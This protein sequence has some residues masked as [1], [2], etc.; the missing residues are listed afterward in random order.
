[1]RIEFGWSLDGASWADAASGGMTGQVR[2]GPRGL[3]GLL[4]TRLGLTRPAIDQAVRIAQYLRLIEQCIESPTDKA[5]FWPARSF[6]LDPWSTARQLLRWRD[7]AVEAGWSPDPKGTILP[8]R[9]AALATIERRAVVGMVGT[10]DAAGNPATLAP[11]AADDLAEMVAELELGAIGWPLGIQQLVAQKDP[12]ALPGLWPRLLELLGRAG[13]EVTRAEARAGGRP[14]VV[15]VQCRD[16]WTAAD[17][18]ARYLSAGPR[19]GLH[20]LATTDTAVLD[21]ALH[22]RDLPA[23]GAVE[24]STDRA[25]HQVLGLYLDVA[26]A[27]VDV[28]QLA[29]LLDLRVLPALEPEGDPIGLVPAPVRRALLRALASE[30]GVGGP[31]WRAALARLEEREDA[32]KV[33]VSAREID[34]LVSDPLPAQAL[35]PEALSTR[36]GWLADRLRA[37]GHRDSDLRASLTQ[38]QTLRQVLG[39]LDPSTTLS[40]RTLQQ[41]ID[42]CGGGGGSTLARREVAEWTVTTRPAQLPATGGTV[43]WWGPEADEVTPPVVW[44]Q[45]EAAALTAAG[46]HLLA[47]EALAALRVEAGS[48]GMAG[49]GTVVAVLPGRRLEEAGRPSSLLARLET[50]AERTEGDRLTPESLVSGD[51]WSLAGRSLEVRVPAAEHPSPDTSAE[52]SAGD[53]THLLPSR[54][55][56]SQLDTLIA[57][58]HRWVLE[59]ALKIRPASVAALPTGPRMIGTLVHAV[60]ETLVQERGRSL[61]PPSG[62]RIEEVFD[63]LVP[64]LASELDLPG[65]SAERAEIRGR[66]R[67]SLAELFGRTA[68]AGLQITGTETRFELPLELPLKTGPHP[69]VIAGSRDVDALDAAGNP[70]V[71]DLKWTSSLRR[72][73]DLYDSGDAIQLATYAWSLAQEG[74]GAG[75]PAE[76]GYFLLRSGE[77]VAADRALDPH[78]RAPMDVGDAWERML[79]SASEALDEI[80]TGQVRLGCRSL[81]DGAGLDTDAPYAK[82]RTAIGKA[83]EAARGRGRV[84]VEDHCGIGDYAQLCGL[85][86]DGR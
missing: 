14:E 77:F 68:A 59:Y 65:R 33:M 23:V 1:M 45:G 28:H 50:D 22:R 17:V 86:G 4:Q 69:V 35:R 63:Q 18:A 79:A 32:A 53:L 41:V 3:L 40:R 30:P 39:M 55:S 13:V 84:L 25:S 29:A 42:A 83:R 47:P 8:P 62:E 10:T 24:S 12:A 80:A 5:Q 38:V 19:E 26:I 81:L 85:I 43:L 49:A 16:E 6:A 71:L 72:Y 75:E 61:T 66:A 57:C 51:R 73:A 20:L 34:R 2:I 36:L 78:R 48:A 54:L 9:L 31:A 46:A 15:V 58:P 64:Q 21:A 67:R 60:V 37:V 7:A 74:V 27:P 44:D 70:L 82:R 11:G 52:R 56:Y 76:V